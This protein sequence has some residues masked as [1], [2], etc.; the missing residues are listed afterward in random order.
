MRITPIKAF[1][2]AEALIVIVVIGV[3]SMLTIPVYKKNF[4]KK[5]FETALKKNYAILNNAFERYEVEQY[6]SISPTATFSKNFGVKKALMKYLNVYYDCKEGEEGQ[7]VCAKLLF[8]KGIKLYSEN[9]F[10]S[11]IE[12]RS[13]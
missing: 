13:E 9:D 11:L 3:I 7:G 6:T 10:Q 1:T 8:S 12:K 5:G 2:L 4:E